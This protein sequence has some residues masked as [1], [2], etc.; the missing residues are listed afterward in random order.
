MQHSTLEAWGTKGS[1]IRRLIR[2][3][4]VITSFFFLLLNLALIGATYHAGEAWFPLTHL[5]CVPFIPFVTFN[6]PRHHT[7]LFC[8]GYHL[9]AQL[10]PFFWPT[11]TLSTWIRSLPSTATLVLF[12]AE[13]FLASPMCLEF[14][15]RSPGQR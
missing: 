1:K 10:D 13:S 11:K 6:T 9:V 7:S 12:S 14:Y 3:A 4:Q 2:S 8:R 5:E 15:P